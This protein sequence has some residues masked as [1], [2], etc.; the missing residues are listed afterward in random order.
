MAE[1]NVGL[2]SPIPGSALTATGPFFGGPIKPPRE[3]PVKIENPFETLDLESLETF[4]KNNRL[5]PKG[6]HSG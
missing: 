1:Q 2:T 5:W 3:E 6:Y 4:F